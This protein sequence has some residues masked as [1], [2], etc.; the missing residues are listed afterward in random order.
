[1]QTLLRLT[2]LG[3]AF[4]LATVVL[5][6]MAVPAVG[7]LW[8]LI[9]STEHRP[10]VTAG[11]TALLA[12]TVLLTWTAFAGRLAALLDRM[13]GILQIPGIILPIATVG[14]AGVLAALGA[15]VGAEMRRLRVPL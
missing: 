15:F 5:G 12:W 7:I 9:A 4:A 13:G 2:L 14:L 8:G 11:A 1:M 3:A 6:W 10:A